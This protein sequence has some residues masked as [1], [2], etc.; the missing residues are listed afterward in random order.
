VNEKTKLESSAGLM[1]MTMYANDQV[2]T[3]LL[4]WI[5]YMDD[6]DTAT[7]NHLNTTV[8]P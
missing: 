4:M 5:S 3:R 1:R 2:E 7:H 8:V 6:Y